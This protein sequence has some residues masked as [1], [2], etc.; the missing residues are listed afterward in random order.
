[1]LW[2]LLNMF[3]SAR[4]VGKAW[5]TQQFIGLENFTALRMTGTFYRPAQYRNSLLLA[6]PAVPSW[7][8]C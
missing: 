4:C 3:S 2:P 5:F 6:L 7:L 1:M 8:S